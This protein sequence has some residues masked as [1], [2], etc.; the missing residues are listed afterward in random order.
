MKFENDKEVG[1]LGYGYGELMDFAETQ[2]K[3]D[4]VIADM[5]SMFSNVTTTK[6]LI[7]SLGTNDF[8]LSST[9]SA[10]FKTWYEN[11]LDDINTE[12]SDIIV[13]CISPL[14]RTVDGALL[15]DYRTAIDDVCSVRSYATHIAG[16]TILTTGAPDFADKVHPSTTGMK[17]YKDAVYTIIS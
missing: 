17:K 10:T 1:I 8:A 4:N 5:V 16:K 14:I 2:L 7:I 9:A 3:R 6:K 15:D 12:D 11:L 13:Y